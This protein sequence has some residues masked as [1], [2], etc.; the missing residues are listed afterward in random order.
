MASIAVFIA[1]GGTGYALTQLPKNSVKAK[2]IARD[3][4]RAAEVKAGAIRT[5]EVA[6]GSLLTADFGVGELPRGGQ[7]A[8]GATGP[9]GAV[10]AQGA[11]GPAGATGEQGDTGS[12]GATGDAGPTGPAGP[13]FAATSPALN[14]D[15]VANP[16]FAPAKSF[17]FTLPTAGRVLVR[18]DAIATTANGVP[19]IRIDCTVGNPTIGLYVDGVPVPDTGHFLAKNASLELSSTGITE[20]AL[21]AGPHTVTVGADCEAGDFF[22]GTISNAA[23]FTVI[24]LGS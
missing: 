24:L 1:L 16:D 15:P 20:S 17:A 12:T 6:D 11:T 23:R 21:S 22:S 9:Q 13:L 18:F 4:V 14:I 8:A 5:G 7:G 10:G 3:A 2:Q 19:G